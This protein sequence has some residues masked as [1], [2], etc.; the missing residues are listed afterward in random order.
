[1]HTTHRMDT[2]TNIEVTAAPHHSRGQRADRACGPDPTGTFGC[3]ASSEDH[4][5]FSGF[6]PLTGTGT[7]TPAVA[8]APTMPVPAPQSPTTTLANPLVGTQPVTPPAI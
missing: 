7:S 2:G 4:V 3:R 5:F 1:M 8:Q 6:T